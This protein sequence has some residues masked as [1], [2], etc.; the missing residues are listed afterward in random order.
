MVKSEMEEVTS[1]CW[2]PRKKEKKRESHHPSSVLSSSIIHSKTTQE[3]STIE[4]SVN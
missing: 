4:I 2:F 3:F 1:S